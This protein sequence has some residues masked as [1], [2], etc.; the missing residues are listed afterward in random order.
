MPPSL[1]RLLPGAALAVV[2]A[3]SGLG[4]LT[5]TLEGPRWESISPLTFCVSA[6][7]GLNDAGLWYGALTDWQ[8]TPTPFSY[9]LSGGGCPSGQVWLTEYP[10]LNPTISTG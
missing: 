9:Q 7:A 3:L 2:L 8:A 10:L 4:A 6:P 1:S 5:Y